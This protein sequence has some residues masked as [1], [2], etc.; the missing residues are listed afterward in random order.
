MSDLAYRL[1][2][3]QRALARERLLRTTPQISARA[4]FHF[5]CAQRLAGRIISGEH[6]RQPNEAA[7]ARRPVRKPVRG[8]RGQ[9]RPRHHTPPRLKNCKN[10][11]IDDG[12]PQNDN[13]IPDSKIDVGAVLYSCSAWTDDKGQTSTEIDDG[14]FA[15]FGHCAVRRAAWDA[16]LDSHGARQSTSTLPGKGLCPRGASSHSKT[17]DYGWLKSISPVFATISGWL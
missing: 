13:P 17:G 2:L 16:P 4:G 11:K 12:H 7:I 5:E 9:Q 15:A 3:Q 6:P 8:E 1:A 10:R 14:S